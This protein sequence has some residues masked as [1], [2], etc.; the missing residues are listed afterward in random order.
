MSYP[1]TG[2]NE[3]STVMTYASS[4]VTIGPFIRYNRSM[5]LGGRLPP[6]KPTDMAACANHALWI[7][8]LKKQENIYR[9][10][11][12]GTRK[13]DIL[14]QVVTDPKRMLAPESSFK[15]MHH[16]PHTDCMP[17]EKRKAN[18]CSNCHSIPTVFCYTCCQCGCRPSIPTDVNLGMPA[19]REINQMGC[20]KQCQCSTCPADR[21][22]SSC[23]KCNCSNCPTDADPYCKCKC[24]SKQISLDARPIVIPILSCVLCFP[25]LAFAI[26]CAL[27]YR[28]IRLR[29]KDRLKRVKSGCRSVTLEIPAR[30]KSSFYSKDSSSDP[31]LK[32]LGEVSQAVPESPPLLM[33][34]STSGTSSRRSSKSNQHVKFMTT[35]AVFHGR[36]ITGLN[37][38]FKST[39][40]K[41]K[42]FW[43][44]HSSHVECAQE[45]EKELSLALNS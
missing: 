44:E 11:H 13:P 31:S 18:R 5:N 2:F 32:G 14:R 35:T 9:K 36:T 1:P 37:G 25:V 23:K 19:F 21:G 33:A 30:D 43:D 22:R 26:I 10:H 40:K 45:L 39:G 28:A 16:Y 7:E 8:N 42:I 27:R 41:Q 3:S 4:P 34:P 20:C 15:E 29:K 12:H 38:R 17:Q 6:P 24:R